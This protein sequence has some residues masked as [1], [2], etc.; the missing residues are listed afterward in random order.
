[1]LRTSLVFAILAACGLAQDPFAALDSDR[2]D[3]V[4]SDE[5]IDAFLQMDTSGDGTA[6]RP[7]YDVFVASRTPEAPAEDP[8]EDG[9]DPF[10]VLD[11]NQDGRLS[12]DEI[13][14]A[15]LRMDASEDGSVTRQELIGFV[16]ART[17]PPADAAR[18][19][20]AGLQTGDPAPDFTLTRLEPAEG[21]AATVTLSELRGQPVLLIFGSYT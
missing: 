11:G 4:S 19:R 1:M 6:T 18:D 10:P 7:E 3:R 5:I 15:F 21:E 16:A 14:D 8:E 2:D 20:P 9:S 17:A 13:I 12:V